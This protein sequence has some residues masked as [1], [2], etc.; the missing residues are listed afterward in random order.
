MRTLQPVEHFL[1]DLRFGARLLGRGP[2]FTAVAVLS[3]ALGIDVGPELA[4]NWP[5]VRHIGHDR[6]GF[7]SSPAVRGTR[8]PVAESLKTHTRSVIGTAAH[9]RRVPVGKLLI[10]GKWRS[11]SCCC[12]ERR[13]LCGA[14]MPWSRWMS[15]RPGS[16]PRGVDRPALIGLRHG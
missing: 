11:P 6:A 9:G 10:A 5:D 2:G 14:F 13:C 16:R 3:L 15:V 8:V 12:L 7:R 4:C 1:R